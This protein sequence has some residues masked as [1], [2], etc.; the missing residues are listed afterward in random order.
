MGI[1]GLPLLIKEETRGAAVRHIAFSKLHD[2]RIAVDAPLIINQVVR[3]IRSKTGRDLRNSKGVLTSHLYGLLKKIIRCFENNIRLVFVFDGK[4][5]E[6]KNHTVKTRKAS[7]EKAQEAM[8]TV[9]VDSESYSR[10]FSQSYKLSEDEITEAKILLDLMGIPHITAP[11]EAD[12]VLSWLAVR[13]NDDDQPYVDGVASDDSDMLVLGTPYLYKD[14]LKFTGRDHIVT[15]L[16]LRK[17][18]TIANLSHKQF[19]D[20]CVLIGSDYSEKLPDVGAKTALRLIRQHRSLTNIHKYYRKHH[21]MTPELETIFQNMKLARNYFRNALQELDEM[22]DFNIDMQDLAL[23]E[24][25]ILE[26]VDFLCNRHEFDTGK[27]GE[28]IIKLQHYQKRMSITS[29]NETDS[30]QIQNKNQAEKLLG[31][32]T[33]DIEF[34]SDTE[35]EP[36]DD[37]DT[38]EEVQN[39]RGFRPKAPGHTRKA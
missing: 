30:Y 10:F 32:M 4:C 29:A 33:G 16:K 36:D 2:K 9:E 26:L 21:E 12:A 11:G 13:C 39:Q 20:L 37:L 17:F 18:L 31:L 24:A 34:R 3:G 22:E 28:D 14:M 19:I 38:D 1:K 5:P 25:K 23:H 7:R 27:V 15:I 35:S 6:I 8:D